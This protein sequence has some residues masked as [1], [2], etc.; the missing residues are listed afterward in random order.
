MKMTHLFLAPLALIASSV[1]ADQPAAFVWWEAEDAIESTFQGPEEHPFRPY[2]ETEAAIL[3]GGKW[4]GF[5]PDSEQKDKVQ[6]KAAFDPY[7]M[8]DAAPE[9]EAAKPVAKAPPFARYAIEVPADG[10]YH[11]YA[12]KFWSHG[13]FRWRFDEG[14]WQEAPSSLGLLDEQSM[15]KFTGANWVGLGQVELSAGKH[16]FTFEMVPDPKRDPGDFVGAYDAFILSPQP[17]LPR[18]KM[19]PGEKYGTTEAGWFA[20]EPDPDPYGPSP[21]DLRWLNEKEAGVN[22]WVRAQGDSLVLGNGQPVRFFAVNLLSEAAAMDH[23]SIDYM[24]DGLAKR[25][26]NMVRVA[27]PPFVNLDSYE[28]FCRVDEAKLDRLFYLITVLKKRGI[29]TSISVYFPLGVKLK[30]ETGLEGYWNGMFSFSVQY[31]SPKFQEAYY[32]WW[33]QLLTTPNPY[34][35][36]KL[37]DDP[38]VAIAELVNEDSYF[39]WTFNQNYNPPEE[40]MRILAKQFGDWSAAKYGSL[41][42]AFET[43]SS[44]VALKGH[45]MDDAEA[46]LAGIL[47]VSELA[48]PQKPRA[49]DTCQFLTESMK[50]FHAEAAGKIR[51]EFGFKGLIYGSNWYTANARVLGPLDKYANSILDVM[52][53][54]GYYGALHEGDPATSYAIPL[55]TIYRDRALVRFDHEKNEG[56]TDFNSPLLDITYQNLPSMITEMGPPSPN[57]YAS[58]YTLPATAYG[59]LQGQD[60]MFW[61]ANAGPTWQQQHTKFAVQVPSIAGQFPGAA[62]LYR[63]GSLQEADTVV[64]VNLLVDDLMQLKGSPLA[65]AA[66]FD[67]LRLADIPKGGANI[68]TKQLETLDI[69]SHFVGKVRVNFTTQA[70]PSRLEDLSPYV[71]RSAKTIRSKTG[72]LFWDYGKGLLSI[73]SA[74]AQGLVGFFGQNGRMTLPHLTCE[75]AMHCGSLL[76]V[77]LDG[78]AI[79]RS[80]NLL[81]QVMSEDRNAGW[82]TEDAGEG[83]KKIVN[84][85]GPPLVV[86]KLEGTVTLKV[87]A[88][89]LRTTALDLNGYPTADVQTGPVIQLRPDVLYYHVHVVHP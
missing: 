87:P 88:S 18:G 42:K 43:W 49:V 5:G 73:N 85:G 69:L 35:G 72:E 58:L 37:C 39:F 59:V 14:A 66:N 80:S 63:A 9:Q 61:F 33:K 10:A 31:F 48:N 11:F 41:A 62:L 47:A 82:K 86:K 74:K 64:D 20:F 51:S 30:K 53:R 7:A 40:Q 17:F 28:S 27:S 29:Y 8:F 25:G 70:V 2:N 24:A 16:T 34:T 4:I 1:F 23:A 55:N 76:L 60:A 46:G 19:K 21:I 84:L 77:P 26:I 68:E 44:G 78:A 15:R 52:D 12:R 54:H 56:A 32:A 38:A 79:A 22:G 3:S 50:R 45:P 6:A 71:N 89:S 75:S 65:D 81:L 13:P 57:R 83:R 36:L 67:Q